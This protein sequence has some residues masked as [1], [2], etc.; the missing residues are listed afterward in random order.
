M[1][2]YQDEITTALNEIYKKHLN[3][4]EKSSFG[5]EPFKK[6]AGWPTEEGR[7]RLWTILYY[8]HP[9]DMS[10]NVTSFN[11]IFQ[12]GTTSKQRFYLNSRFI[13]NS[14]DEAIKIYETRISRLA[15]VYREKH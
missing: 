13:G 1:D 7:D 5:N 12:E 4:L 9:K 8:S 15:K 11:M 14:F 10:S 2:K 6:T 3:S